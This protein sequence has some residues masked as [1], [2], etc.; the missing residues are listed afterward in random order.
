MYASLLLLCSFVFPRSTEKKVGYLYYFSYTKFIELKDVLNYILVKHIASNTIPQLQ[1][2]PVS[3]VQLILPRLIIIYIIL[4][5]PHPE[6]SD[7]NKHFCT[8]AIDN[9]PKSIM[10][11]VVFIID[12][13]YKMSMNYQPIS[14]W[15]ISQEKIWKTK[16]EQKGKEMQIK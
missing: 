2:A 1:Q 6:Q 10:P 5:R 12:W 11:V 9:V 3:I 8:C 16:T 13:S 15:S 14:S 7:H 4:V